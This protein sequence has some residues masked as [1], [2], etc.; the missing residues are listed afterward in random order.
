MNS[1]RL[2]RREQNNSR[3][4]SFRVAYRETDLWIAV[5]TGVSTTDLT[6]TVEKLLVKLRVSLDSY[7]KA[8]PD[9]KES[10]QPCPVAA[11][12]PSILKK[13]AI[14]ANLAGVGPMAAVAGAFAE[15]VGS[16]LAKQHLEVVVENGGDLYIQVKEPILVGIYAG[17]SSIS[18]QLALKINPV[19]TPMGICTS[20]GT[21]GPSLSFGQADAVVVLSASAALADAAAT[22]LG[23]LVSSPK[24][25]NRTLAAAQQIEGIS[26]VL[27]VCG[28]KI[29]A[30]G[31]LE[32][33]RV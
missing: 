20:S 13:M 22:A 18:S 19:L 4:A 27:L 24:D 14:A 32:L 10:L 5:S 9:L 17:N 30:W 11:D 3:F 15:A 29:A 7:L 28:D 2:Y 26:G 33:T 8:H 25:F 1:I 23:N 21:V 12:A 16:M 6:A 31:D